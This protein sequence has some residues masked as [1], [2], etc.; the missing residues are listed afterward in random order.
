MENMD[1]IDDEVPSSISRNIYDLP[2]YLMI[3]IFSNLSLVDLI[4]TFDVSQRFRCIMQT[5]L[6]LRNDGF[7]RVILRRFD[8]RD[9][10]YIQSSPS[11][12]NCVVVE[13]FRAVL[14]F[15]RIFKLRYHSLCIN[16]E[17]ASI[18]RQKIVFAQVLAHSRA[19]IR[20]L[21]MKHMKFEFDMS[22]YDVFSQVERLV[23]KFCH[24]FEDLCNLQFRFPNV[25]DITFRAENTFKDVFIALRRYPRLKFMK[26]GPGTLNKSMYQLL[27]FLNS[28]TFFAYRDF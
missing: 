19:T 24:L 3:K 6:R 13:G 14:R 9:N 23:F 7:L 15:L 17:R 5:D 11:R 21:Y 26:V 16:Y 10:C 12:R 1:I 4:T 20:Y 28:D 27:G 18:F 25:R 8:K 2:D 22:L